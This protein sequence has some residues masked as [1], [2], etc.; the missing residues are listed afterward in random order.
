MLRRAAPVFVL[1]LSVA[2][3]SVEVKKKDDPKP[4]TAAT[5]PAPTTPA[6]DA[7]TPAPSE[8]AP[9][10]AKGEPAPETVHSASGLEYR[11]EKVGTGATPKH[12]QVVIVNYRGTFPDGREFDSSYKR[13]EP[14]EFTLGVGAVIK[15]WDEGVAS[16]RV[17]GKRHLVI[18]PQLAYGAEGAGDG[19]IPPNATLVFHVELLGVR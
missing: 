16:M 7:K 5:K 1:A 9:G 13:N 15:G 4:A 3:C 14:F 2:G 18:P 10:I 17:G 12:G 19:L 8:P 6:A 11:D